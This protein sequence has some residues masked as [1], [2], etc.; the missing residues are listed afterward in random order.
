MFY[1]KSSVLHINLADTLNKL[2][3]SVSVFESIPLLTTECR[4]G[5]GDHRLATQGINTQWV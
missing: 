3:L 2:K 1:V 4:D 5:H